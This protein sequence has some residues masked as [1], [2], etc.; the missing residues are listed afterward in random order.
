MLF[1]QR[2]GLQFLQTYFSAV[3]CSPA[4]W[5]AQAKHFFALLWENEYKENSRC[6]AQ[7]QIE[8]Y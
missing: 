6:E 5:P 4:G 8:I 7:L 3:S 1:N 2:K